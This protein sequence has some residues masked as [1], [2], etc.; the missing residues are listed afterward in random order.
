MTTTDGA[1]VRR[2][3]QPDLSAVLQILRSN[4]LPESGVAEWIENFIVVE[5][6]ET[7]LAAA[8]YELYGPYALLRSVVVAEGERNTGIGTRLV[9]E[10]LDELRSRQVTDVYLLTTTA[11]HYFSRQGFKTV[12]RESLP[13][14]L[15]ASEELIHACPASA[16]VMHRKLTKQ[17]E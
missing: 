6:A 4:G 3:E 1:V 9:H 2:A 8:G 16:C 13:Q 11:E 15:F 7:L 14:P 10:T 5:E 17:G 12:E